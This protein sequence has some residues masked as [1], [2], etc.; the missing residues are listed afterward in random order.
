[1]RLQ[2][3][4]V[5]AVFSGK[6]RNQLLGQ[7][8]LEILQ[9]VHS[10]VRG[11][12]AEEFPCVL[13]VDHSHDFAL[14]RRSQVVEDFGPRGGI[15]VLEHCPRFLSREALHEIGRS[16]RMER[17]TKLEQPG[18]VVLGQMQRIDHGRAARK[19]CS[20]FQ[21][22]KLP[23]HAPGSVL[24]RPPFASSSRKRQVLYTNCSARPVFRL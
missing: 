23:F 6:F 12:I 13:A 17:R 2:A 22:L 20:R 18:R 7:A 11:E 15:G 1:M 3:A 19:T 10:V 4:D 9:Q 5:A 21:S 8:R 16:R 24:G 14:R